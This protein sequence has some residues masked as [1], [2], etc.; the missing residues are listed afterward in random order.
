MLLWN[1]WL[2]FQSLVHHFVG[3]LV[4]CFWSMKV[5]G[6]GWLAGYSTP[7][8]CHTTAGRPVLY[9][10]A[11]LCNLMILYGT[12]DFAGLVSGVNQSAILL[13]YFGEI[14]NAIP[15]TRVV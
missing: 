11:G 3:Y 12:D 10:L 9:V 5:A 13:Y 1:S 14:R 15:Q 6:S 4:H 2:K 8:S 7:A